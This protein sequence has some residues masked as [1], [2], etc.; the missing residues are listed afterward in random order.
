MTSSK[1]INW[2]SNAVLGV[3]LTLILMADDDDREFVEFVEFVTSDSITNNSSYCHEED[4]V[5]TF[6]YYNKSFLA[7]FDDE[8]EVACK[9]YD[10]IISTIGSYLK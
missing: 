1:F 9:A 3:H 10:A 8:D 7:Y 5:L 6:P 4:E 2:G